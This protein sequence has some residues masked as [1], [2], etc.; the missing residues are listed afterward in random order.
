MFDMRVLSI[1][2]LTAVLAMASA[3]VADAPASQ[4]YLGSFATSVLAGG[5]TNELTV[6]ASPEDLE[7]FPE[8]DAQGITIKWLDWDKEKDTARC[9]RQLETPKE[10]ES[11]AIRS[12]KPVDNE[13]KKTRLL[14]DVPS[15]PC[16]WPINQTAQV[17]IK[18]KVAG[19][20]EAKTLFDEKIEISVF[21]F[22]L[23]VTLL[24][25][26]LI[27]PGC[28]MVAF[29]TK[30]RRYEKDC[31]VAETKGQP[32]PEKPH[33]LG[34]LD[35]VQITANPFGRGSLAKLQIFVFS[36][37]VFGLL[38]YYQFR[39]GVLA[40]MSVDV[41]T[42][43]GISAVGAVGGK[44]TYVYKRRLSFE[45]WAWLRRKGWLPVGKDVAPRAR[46]SELFLDSD[47]REFDP[48]SFQMAVFSLVVAVALLR[49]GLSGLGT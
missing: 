22:P 41:M 32:K 43:M 33:F 38:F 7:L 1:I 39:Y 11:I 2:T 29:Y 4:K 30:Q 9:R 12:K 21:W 16:I 6:P 49:S 40:G 18:A 20:S 45:N 31:K 8:T 13:I 42:L 35:P 34:T 46:W 3:A 28:A 36:L 37:L 17:T 14:I 15:P 44:V 24:V 27:Y 26:A 23:A 47:T 25:L 5:S 19:S 10:S 48:Y